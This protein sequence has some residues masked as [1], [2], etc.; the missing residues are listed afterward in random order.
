MIFRQCVN[1]TRSLP[2]I[3]SSS[4]SN[5]VSRQLR[6]RSGAAAAA[7]RHNALITRS[8]HSKQRLYTLHKRASWLKHDNVLCH[9]YITPLVTFRVYSTDK[10]PSSSSSPDIPIHLVNPKIDLTQTVKHVES[11]SSDNKPSETDDVSLREE[12]KSEEY[13]KT[14]V[15]SDVETVKS[16]NVAASEELTVEKLVT[17]ETPKT[18][19]L[20]LSSPKPLIVRSWT[21]F[22]GFLRHNYDGCKLLFIEVKISSRLSKKIFRGES[23]T[24][25]EQNQLKR[26]VGDV[27]RLV[28]FAMFII[29]PFMELL[30]PV[31]LYFFPG[32]LPSTFETIDKKREK[33]LKKLKLKLD[34]AKFVQDSMVSMITTQKAKPMELEKFGEFIAKTRSSDPRDDIEEL[35][36][37]SKLFSEELTLDN[38]PRQYLVAICQLIN[39][40][41]GF[42]TDAFLRFRLRNKMNSL[43]KDD[44][45]IRYEGLEAMTGLELQN[46]NAE[47]GMRAVGVSIERL[48]NQL[49]QWMILSLDKK[50]PMSLLLLSRVSTMPAG[51]A[52]TYEDLRNAVAHLPATLIG[53]AK[54]TL[55]AQKGEKI[56]NRSR[57]EAVKAQ[58]EMI[59]SEK[60]QQARKDLIDSEKDRIKE[61]QEAKESSN[62]RVAANLQMKKETLKDMAKPILT[63]D[64]IEFRRQ[65]V[66]EI[67]QLITGLR[68]KK[69]PLLEEKGEL[70][71]LIEKALVYHM[72]V[73]EGSVKASAKNKLLSN[74]VAKMLNHSHK[75][76]T[77]LETGLQQERDSSSEVSDKSEDVV[78]SKQEIKNAINEI[79]NVSKKDQLMAILEALPSDTGNDIKT[80]EVL[81]GLEKIATE[82]TDLTAKEISYVMKLTQKFSKE[83]NSS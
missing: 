53:E 16:A 44:M 74:K 50:I 34:L 61:E 43:K 39:I 75:V 49:D 83:D 35:V 42:H 51:N 46:A 25:R 11:L 77:Q 64:Q 15:K 13:T 33:K 26:T 67:Q 73:E 65:E 66:A 71:D 28:P 20:V 70:R 80:S 5:G 82:G 21:A 45:M 12:K 24:R 68:D 2:R 41:T 32:M 8:H 72:T 79:L 58:E 6:N 1:C 48:R 57:I 36:S 59:K 22:K 7:Q 38:L 40:D 37:F 78:L 47:R 27:F 31:A 18:T 63:E 3:V 81:K 17:V 4:Y 9:E 56:D 23:L 29:I 62:T 76:L 55:A 60:D 52:I 69:N 14:E 30:L 54:I 10:S 19:S